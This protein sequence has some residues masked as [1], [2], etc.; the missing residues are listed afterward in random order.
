MVRRSSGIAAF[1]PG[2]RSTGAVALLPNGDVF[3]HRV[4]SRRDGASITG[5]A[6]WVAKQATD[7]AVDLEREIYPAPSATFRIAFAVEGIVAI[8]PQARRRPINPMPLVE[9][10][11]VLGAIAHAFGEDLVVVRPGNHGG[12]ELG[13]Y[14]AELVTDAERRLDGWQLRVG[15]TS[16]LRHARSAYDVALAVQNPLSSTGREF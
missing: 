16:K 8:V 15:K 2:S 4:W 9:T 13:Y 1:D 6:R 5:Y 7:L 11:V 10:G 14:P 12:N 3:R